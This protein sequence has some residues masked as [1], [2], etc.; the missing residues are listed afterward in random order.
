MLSRAQ[1]GTGQRC[2]Q[3]RTRKCLCLQALQPNTDVQQ[4]YSCTCTVWL[5]LGYLPRNATHKLPR[6]PGPLKRTT[7]PLRGL[8]TL[9]PTI[10]GSPEGCS[11]PEGLPA[12]CPSS[13][14]A[15]RHAFCQA[16]APPAG[17]SCACLR[18]RCAHPHNWPRRGAA[19]P[20]PWQQNCSPSAYTLTGRPSAGGLLG[21]CSGTSSSVSALTITTSA[22]WD[23][24][25]SVA[26]LRLAFF[27]MAAAWLPP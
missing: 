5:L 4:N 16:G 21:A 10:E 3:R 22:G 18:Q 17:V 27:T 8:A 2:L 7:G 23:L 14:V 24:G 11:N 1:S 12:A 19:G 6:G 9:L 15:L 25:M 20:L 13:C 26:T